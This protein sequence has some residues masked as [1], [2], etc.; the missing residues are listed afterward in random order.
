MLARACDQLVTSKLSP[1]KC[2]RCDWP[3]GAHARVAPKAVTQRRTKIWGDTIRQQVCKSV[4]CN[5]TVYFAQNVKTGTFMPFDG[6][7]QA[8]AVEVEIQTGREIWLIDLATS[9]FGSCVA[10]PSFRRRA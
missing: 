3:S 4:R 1:D 7:P 8:L 9:H 10:A 2:V 6:R 5:K